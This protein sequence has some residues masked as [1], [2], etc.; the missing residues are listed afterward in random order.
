MF[1]FGKRSIQGYRDAL[2]DDANTWQ[3]GFYKFCDGNRKYLLL[4]MTEV[5]AAIIAAMAN[6]MFRFGNYDPKVSEDPSLRLAVDEAFKNVRRIP[7]DENRTVELTAAVIIA[8]AAQDV[9]MARFKAHFDRLHALGLV[10]K[11]VNIHGIESRLAQ[12]HRPYYYYM[13]YGDS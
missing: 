3:L 13:Q 4:G 9:P 6:W 2:I 7:T 12:E 8:A 1:G 5:D 10:T 11:R